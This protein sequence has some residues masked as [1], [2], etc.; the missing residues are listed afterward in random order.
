MLP[1]GRRGM[2]DGVTSMAVGASTSCSQ[3]DQTGLVPNNVKTACK[4]WQ[5]PGQQPRPEA[6]DITH[7]IRCETVSSSQL[8]KQHI[9]NPS[10]RPVPGP[11][12]FL[13]CP[14]STRCSK[15]ACHSASLAGSLW[16]SACCS[17]LVLHGSA[18]GSGLWRLCTKP[19]WM[20]C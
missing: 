9:K 15:R 6:H 13:G 18:G 7:H 8:I 17:W 1:T 14:V 3:G 11:E 5:L 4:R 19:S 10:T 12:Y 2:A 16:L 20:Q